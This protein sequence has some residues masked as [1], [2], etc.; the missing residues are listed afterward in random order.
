[1][2]RPVPCA[3]R[4][5]CRKARSSWRGSGI[6]ERRPIR[7][8]RG[9]QHGPS[10]DVVHRCDS[11]RPPL[12]W[13]EWMPVHLGGPRRQWRLCRVSCPRRGKTVNKENGSF[14]T[15][16]IE[17]TVHYGRMYLDSDGAPDGEFATRWEWRAG[18]GV[19]VE[20][21]RLCWWLDQARVGG[22]LWTQECSSERW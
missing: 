20:S 18:A 8:R 12:E 13:T 19:Q 5:T 16:Y 3:R 1:M 21:R 17:A 7:T 2:R 11:L 6:V 22:A 4:R 9:I 10:R 15:N 14:S